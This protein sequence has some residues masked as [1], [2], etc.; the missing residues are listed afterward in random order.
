M[1][2]LKK[3]NTNNHVMVDME[4]LDTGS[5]P[6]ILKLSAVFFNPVTGDTSREF[7]RA[8]DLNSSLEQGLTVSASTLSWWL[9]TNSN[10]LGEIVEEGFTKEGGCKE[11]TSIYSVL[12]DFSMFL[13]HGGE[14]VNMWGKGPSF[15]LA[16]LKNVY[17]KLGLKAPWHFSNEK[18]VRTIINLKPE[19]KEIEFE[20]TIHDPIDDCKHQIRMVHKVF[21][22][23]VKHSR[24][25]TVTEDV[26]DMS[27]LLEQDFSRCKKLAWP[28]TTDCNT[29]IKPILGASLENKP[30]QYKI[31][32]D[33]F[34]RMECNTTLEERLGFAKGNIDKYTWRNK[35]QDLED[36][37]KIIAY[38]KWAIKQIKNE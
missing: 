38:A 11:N 1:I 24:G 29:L 6:V 21:R 15:D 23:W 16:K 20:G 7:N 12:E 27:R 2:D 30:T 3:Y 34:K 36:Y 14:G 13:L 5:H 8:I 28:F 17:N 37:E 19:V 9:K 10:L 4:T 26:Q 31:G 25:L 18:C 32:I 22:L 35:G 33:T